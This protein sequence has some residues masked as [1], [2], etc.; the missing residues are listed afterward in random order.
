[1]KRVD[2][3]YALIHNTEQN[4]VLMVKNVGGP[5]T[6]PGG[7][8]EKGESLA[9]AAARE[10]REETGLTV[11]IGNLVALNE[12]FIAE[13]G[14]H[15]IFFTFE[16]TI[17]DGKP[18]IQDEEEISEVCWMDTAEASILVPYYTKGIQRLSEVSLPYSVE[19]R[20]ARENLHLV[21]QE[22]QR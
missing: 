11:K 6:L 4:E 15:A 2:V 14:H 5:W 7:A 3:V 13:R 18:G 16:A 8:A 9:E 17:L 22:G 10:V 12:V 19:R 21:N 1:M 20:E